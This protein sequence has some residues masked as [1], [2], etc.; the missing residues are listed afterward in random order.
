MGYGDDIMATGIARAAVARVREVDGEDLKVAFGYHDPVGNKVHRHFSPVFAGNPFIVQPDE[1]YT[2][3]LVLLPE[4]PGSRFYIDYEQMRPDAQGRYS[5]F[6]FRADA[7]AIRGEFFFSGAEDA[8]AEAATAKFP[9]RTILLEPN[10]KLDGGGGK[11]KPWPEAYWVELVERLRRAGFESAQVWH[12]GATVDLPVRKVET[13]TFREA[14]AVVRHF[15]LLVT[16]DGGLHHASAAV[17][18]DAVVLW[19]HYSS[20]SLFG[21][22]DHTNVRAAGYDGLGCGTILNRC[23]ECQRSM[24]ELS[25]AAVAGTILSKLGADPT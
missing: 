17:D 2:K 24:S 6:V 23:A 1:D 10:V 8:A 25:P 13:K 15:S 5:H 11:N 7:T 21:Y 19:G 18:G 12:D 14:A 22:P 4:Y 16:T 9:F 3:A 20:P